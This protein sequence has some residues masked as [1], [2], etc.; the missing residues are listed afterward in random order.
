[1]LELGSATNTMPAP[2]NFVPPKD[3]VDQAL[4]EEFKKFMVQHSNSHDSKSRGLI[5]ES[6][7]TVVITP[8]K[9][10]QDETKSTELVD[11]DASFED[12]KLDEKLLWG[13]SKMGFVKPSKIQAAALPWIVRQPNGKLGTNL[14][15]QAQNGSGKTGAFS[16]AILSVL[17]IWNEWP[18]ALVLCPTR[19]LARQNESVIAS[20]GEFLPV[21]TL[22]LVPSQDRIP[23]NAE[24]H[25]LIGTP[26]KTLDLAKKKIVD[27]SYLKVLVL[28]E[29]DVMLDEANQM[30][31]QVIQIRQFLPDQDNIQVLFFSA[32]YP[33]E[34]RD[35]AESQ[36]PKS[37]SI[38]V[39]KEE[40]TL[41][42]V[43]QLYVNCESQWDKFDKLVNLYAAMN[44]GQSVVFVNRR[45]T[46]FELA[47]W[48][49]E[50]GFPVSLICGT[51]LT[52]QEWMDPALRDNVMDEFRNNVTRVLIA[53]DVLSRGI[54][55]PQVTL[56]V[57]YELPINYHTGGVD[58]E[59]YIHRVGR[60]GRFGLKG[61]S[62]N[63]VSSNEEK[64]TEDIC[65]FYKCT[66]TQI[67][68]DFEVLEEQL[69]QLR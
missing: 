23:K 18:Q 35:F 63:L 36:A 65:A 1:V 6:Q 31:S 45:K 55:V 38:V 2:P 50:K 26:G 8:W 7:A 29:A 39:K 52:G 53:T 48:M 64:M 25:V 40:L 5:N 68:S 56:V 58:M 42:C 9:D 49:K 28:D 15:G 47:K 41:T 34:V 3:D 27:L 11:K 24:V 17:D 57:N 69:K 62:V 37:Y 21:K 12:Y 32:T 43:K 66:I 51:Q 14:I 20:L 59:T 61:V 30:G 33:D 54:D 13:I 19:E 46:A 67:G 10:S 44:V 22:V 60:T 16:L 4:L